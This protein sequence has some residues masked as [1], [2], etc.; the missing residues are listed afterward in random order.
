M[1]TSGSVTNSFRVHVICPSTKNEKN[2]VRD[3]RFHSLYQYAEVNH[4]FVVVI[5]VVVIVVVVIVVVIIVVVEI[6][7]VKTVARFHEY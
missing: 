2:A 6:V 4:K 3:K 1:L 7:V 5:V